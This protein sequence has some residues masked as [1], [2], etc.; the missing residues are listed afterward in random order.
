MAVESPRIAHELPAGAAW[1]EEALVRASELEA[2]TASFESWTDP[3]QR[4]VVSA[5]LA[6][7]HEAVL[8]RARRGSWQRLKGADVLRATS[9]LDAAETMVLRLA[10]DEYLKAQLPSIVL[11]VQSALPADD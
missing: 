7:S 1:R 10:P 9:N 8:G 11:H 4:A 5:H 2:L 6:A 3:R